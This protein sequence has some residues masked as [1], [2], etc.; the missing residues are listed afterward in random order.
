M[1]RPFS[2]TSNTVKLYKHLDRLQKL[3]SGIVSPILIHMSPTNKCQMH[4]FHCCFKNRKDKTL[5]MPFGSLKEG[6]SQFH[7]LGA[8]AVELT[9][10]GEP[11]LYSHINETI[12]FLKLDLGMHMGINTNAL[13]SQRVKHWEYFDWIRVSFNTLD[14]YDTINI[15]PIRQSGAYISG[16]YIWNDL[17]TIEVFEKIVR[18]ADE[19]KIVCRIAPDCIRPLEEIDELVEKV[20]GIVE[21]Y[22]SDYIF[23]SDF[24]ID[25]YRH[26]TKCYLHLIKPFFYTDGYI[27]PCPST[28]LVQ[29]HNFQVNPDYR[30]CRYDEVLK[31]YTTN[32]L[33]IPE[34]TCSYCKYAKQQIVLEEVLTKTTFNEFA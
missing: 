15:G 23:L 9:G 3:Q 33:D 11:S 28:E 7:E 5:D 21:R 6:M 27:Y 17:T 30:V 12:E 26:N 25:T 34:R 19:H 1:K 22:E 4:C 29:E 2:H 10:G 31:F 24:N 32:A 18:F 13:E 16:C 14:F 20:R 8:R